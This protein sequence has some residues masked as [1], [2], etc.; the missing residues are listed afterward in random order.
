M[1]E[2][3]R[4]GVGMRKR[5]A[6][7]LS[8]VSVAIVS[9]SVSGWS[10]DRPNAV[11]LRPS[12]A[13]TIPHTNP[14]ANLTPLITPAVKGEGVW[15]KTGRL[16]QGYPVTKRTFLRPAK[17]HYAQILWIDPK[18]G[19]FRLYAGTTDP[20]G[21]GWRYQGWV[22][23]AARPIL[24]AAV[25][26]GFM[27][28]DG[29]SHGGFYA[30]GKYGRA[31]VKGAASVVLFKDG[32]VDVG[33]WGTPG[34]TMTSSVLAV[35]QTLK[36]M[37]AAGNIQPAVFGP[38]QNWGATL[39]PG[40]YAWRSGIG[41]RPD[42][43]VIYVIGNYLSPVYLARV[44]QRAGCIRAMELDINPEWPAAITYTPAPNQPLKVA[45][46][47]ISGS[48]LVSPLRYLGAPWSRDFFAV[49]LR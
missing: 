10:L 15:V 35:R 14:P 36:L 30:Y 6:V 17:G 31:L 5:L 24:A 27:L 22:T 34:F 13:R 28:N 12:S 3:V 23:G 4:E 11:G 40:Q 21:G 16:N 45:P 46:H 19:Q 8:L 39:L 48:S 1:P 42:G 18:V 9:A 25:N 37:V 7:L 29:A 47:K 49:V 32:S 33:S 2:G 38:W 41:V 44:L 43:S 20:G 26:S